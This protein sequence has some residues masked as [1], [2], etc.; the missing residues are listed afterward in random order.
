M[1][2][3]CLAIALVVSLQGAYM[4]F[5][6]RFSWFLSLLG[7]LYNLFTTYGN[8][9]QVLVIDVQIFSFAISRNQYFFFFLAFFLVLNLLIVMLGRMIHSIPGSLFFVPHAGFWTSSKYHRGMA[10]QILS[11]WT[12]VIAATANYFM[13]FWMLVL[14]DTF[15]FEGGSQS[16]I[17]WFYKPGI[18]MAVS[19]LLP[20]I[21]L[22]ILNPDLL[23]Q[24]ERE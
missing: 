7:F 16:A 14:E 17:G 8:I 1:H 15:H 5:F 21:R 23:A 9:Q 10:N 20:I 24:R 4:K 13:I 22:F 12:W 11:N 3:L 19:L 6:A 18:L 2:Y